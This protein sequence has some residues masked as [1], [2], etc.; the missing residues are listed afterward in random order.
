MTVVAMPM[1]AVRPMEL[2]DGWTAKSSEHITISNTMA[3]KKMALLC[4]TRSLL[5]PLRAMASRPSITKML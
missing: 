4:Q 5:E 3:E 2:M 1:R